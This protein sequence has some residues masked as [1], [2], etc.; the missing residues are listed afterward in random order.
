M[1]SVVQTRGALSADE[2]EEGPRH[3]KGFLMAQAEI[4]SAFPGMGEIVRLA[5]ELGLTSYHA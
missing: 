2:V 1:L 4:I 5:R 3:F